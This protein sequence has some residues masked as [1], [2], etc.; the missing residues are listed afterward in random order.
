[1][2]KWLRCITVPV[3]FLLAAGVYLGPSF[4]AADTIV[5][6]FESSGTIQP[7]WVVAIKP[8]TSNTVEL[9]PAGKSQ[10]LYGVAIDP[11][12]APVTLQ[13]QIGQQ[14]FVATSGNYPVL[15]STQNG[16][17]K[18]GDYLSISNTDGIAAKATNSQAYV[19]GQ[20]LQKFD[21]TSGV[22]SAGA[23]NSSIGRIAVS[24]LVQHNPGLKNN[25][26]LPSFLRSAGDSIAGKEV[27]PLRIYAAIAALTI[28][29]LIAFGTLAVGVRSAMTAIGRNP[30]SRQY[31]LRGLVQVVVVSLMVL[32][33]GLISVYLLLRL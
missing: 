30:L 21:G 33:V 28:A 19:V 29:G 4:V 12:H 1:M 14:V 18:A 26:A 25:V 31:L 11:S 17:I 23:G 9:A 20:A 3:F 5:Q 27:T 8:G 22:L 2:I 15:V 6:S 13:R 32:I 24:V 7:D 10:L 16:P